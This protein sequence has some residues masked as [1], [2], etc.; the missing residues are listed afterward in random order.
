[1]KVSIAENEI[2]VDWL[3]ATWEAWHDLLN[4]DG[5]KELVKMSNRR[6]SQA[7]ENKKGMGK[8]NKE[9]AGASQQ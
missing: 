9:G 7:A 3:D 6:L 2:K 8:G 1:M 5:Y 4:T